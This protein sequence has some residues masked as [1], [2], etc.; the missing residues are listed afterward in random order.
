MTLA[1]E[2]MVMEGKPAL[3][4]LGDGWTT[5]TKDG[6]ISAHYENTLVVT[7]EGYEILTIR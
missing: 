7:K 4:T 2:P 3:R 5:V 1:I 6:R